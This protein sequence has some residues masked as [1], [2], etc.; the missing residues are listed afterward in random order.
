MLELVF[1]IVVI[2]IISV[3][4]LPRMSDNNLR[5]AADQVVSHIRYTQHLAMQ[6]DKF[7][8]GDLEWF[9]GSW[10]IRFYEN[11]SFTNTACPKDRDKDEKEFEGVW[12]YVIFSDKPSYTRNPNLTEMARNPENPSQ[13]LS[14][15]YNNTLC[16][17]NSDN[18]VNAQSM[19][20]LR[21]REEYGITS[22]IF[23]G[24]CRSNIQYISFD[25]LGR[26]SNSFANTL[27]YELASPGWHKLLTQQCRIILS[28]ETDSI[29]IAIE[30]ETGFV[31]IL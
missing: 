31:H 5:T 1:V 27:P 20:Q 30:P 6:D 18:G 12:A 3:V 8:P 17:D 26:P 24:G 14:G 10:T 23:S 16:V 13:F 19:P 28:N 9:K 21:L 4:A 22:I 7:D 29:T 25:S 15:G 11:L 2:G